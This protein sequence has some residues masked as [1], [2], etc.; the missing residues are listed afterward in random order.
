MLAKLGSEF[1]AVG[2]LLT[3][4]YLV[5]AARCM[6]KLRAGGEDSRTTFARCIVVAYAVDMFVRGPGYFTESTLLFVVAVSAL[7]MHRGLAR[8]PGAARNREAPPAIA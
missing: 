6:R 5:S 3:I 2:L 4:L 8:T 1:G 7:M